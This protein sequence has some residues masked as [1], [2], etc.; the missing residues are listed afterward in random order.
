[1]S[2]IV[3]PQKIPE[4]LWWEKHVEYTFVLNASHDCNLDLLSPLAGPAEAISDA[5]VGNNSKYFII[6]FKRTL[7]HFKDEYKKFLNGKKGIEEALAELSKK[8]LTSF[9]FIIAGE[10][11]NKGLELRCTKYFD[12]SNLLKLNGT[13]FEEGMTKD[14]LLEYAKLFTNFK[15][16]DQ[17]N[18]DQSS[19]SSS[20]FYYTKH[21][22]AIRDDKKC[23]VLP[24]SF[25][26]KPKPKPKLAS[27]VKIR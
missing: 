9:H 3:T 19:G 7:E 8:K 12:T 21:V 4:V 14:Q 20:D 27:K 25:Y 6:E 10:L 5:I 18:D 16:A 2:D 23:S 1:M 11:G 13:L 15:L 22:L 26:Y 17:N 24:L